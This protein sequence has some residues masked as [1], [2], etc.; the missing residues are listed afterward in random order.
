[1]RPYTLLPP[2]Q[3]VGLSITPRFSHDVALLHAPTF[4]GGMCPRNNPLMYLD[5]F[6]RSLLIDCT[7]KIAEDNSCQ[8]EDTFQTDSTAI[9]TFTTFNDLS[10][11][12]D[13][14]FQQQKHPSSHLL[15]HANDRESPFHAAPNASGLARLASN[16]K[17]I[18]SDMRYASRTLQRH[19]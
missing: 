17:Y 13:E 10:S 15:L 4:L 7:F 3:V 16:T 11:A 2:R 5:K 9:I 6:S 8:V 1:M 19:Q 14:V 18:D 12:S